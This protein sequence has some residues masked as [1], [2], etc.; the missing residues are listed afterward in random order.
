MQHTQR[1]GHIS[2]AIDGR[3]ANWL[4]GVERLLIAFRSRRNNERQYTPLTRSVKHQ[5]SIDVTVTQPQV[6][7]CQTGCGSSRR[8]TCIR[9]ST[10]Q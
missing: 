4:R 7:K 1:N 10:Q 8:R 6:S 2:P 9:L 5:T 3:D